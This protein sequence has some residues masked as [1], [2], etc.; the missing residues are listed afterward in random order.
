MVFSS[1]L[2]N[3]Q[4]IKDSGHDVPG[5]LKIPTLEALEFTT[6]LTG[7]NGWYDIKSVANVMYSSIIGIPIRGQTAGSDTAFKANT[8]YMYTDCVIWR[9]DSMTWE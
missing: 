8:S 2:L 3:P 9:I 6:A 1:A 4:A 7:R 5:N